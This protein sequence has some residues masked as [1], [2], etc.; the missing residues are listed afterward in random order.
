M[1]PQWQGN[2]ALCVIVGLIC[3]T[4]IVILDR[5]MGWWSWLGGPAA[6]LCLGIAITVLF[7]LFFRWKYRGGKQ[8]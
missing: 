7:Q 6:V 3:S 2:V 5:W 8:S 1:G 4:F